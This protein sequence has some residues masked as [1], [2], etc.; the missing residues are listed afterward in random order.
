M[1]R[2]RPIHCDPTR[3]QARLRSRAAAIAALIATLIAASGCHSSD[4]PAPTGADA[5]FEDA[6]ESARDATAQDATTMDGTTL[7]D[8]ST[9]RLGASLVSRRFQVGEHMRASIEMQLSG[10]PFAQLLGYNLN[11]FVRT[12]TI[13]DQYQ[14]T[15]TSSI[16]RD[17]LG[18]A[19]AI[20]SYE[21]SKQPM[22]NLSFESGAGLSLMFG[23]VLNPM[24]LIGDP[25]FELLKQR[26]QLFALEA[27]AEGATMVT[28]PAPRMNPLNYYGWPGLR[29]VFAEFSSFDPTI[30]PDP[31]VVQA[32]PIFGSLTYGTVNPPPVANY[33]CDYNSLNL[34]DRE[35][36]VD[37]TL[38]LGALGYVV[39]KQGLW[40]INYW[41]SL[42]DRS[43][44]PIISVAP[45][46][47]AEVGVPGNVVVGQY[48]DP[49]DPTGMSLI[50][51]VP[52]VYLGD[53]PIEGWQGQLMMDEIDNKSA[54]LLGTLTTTDGSRLS[55]LP[56]ILSAVD[57]DY[58]SP[59]RFFPAVV[60]VE[61]TKTTTVAA[62]ANKFFPRPSAFSVVDGTSR[63]EVLSGLIGG[64]AEAFAFTDQNNAAVG[65]SI[66]FLVTF[67]GDPFASDDGLAD[68]ESTL[69]DRALGI[70]KIALVDLDR[71]HLDP[72]AMVL[73]DTAS[74]SGGAIRR[75]THVDAVELALA[76]VALR[77]AYRS[78]NGSL[79]LYSNDT[80]DTLGALSALD[81]TSTAGASYTGTLSGHITV[82]IKT[83]AD[84]IVG[85]LIDEHGAVANG[86]DLGAA[87]RDPGP[88][89]LEAEA[90]VIR[91]L[92]EA[93][94]ATSD[95]RYRARAI[96]VYA[97]LSTRFWQSDV[98][99]Y[100]TTAGVDDLMQ[101]TPLRHG[102]LQGALRQ[103][104][105]LV[106]SSPG[107]SAE[108]AELL[109]RIKRSMKLVLNGWDD[110]NQDDRIQYPE[111][112]LGFGLEMAERA[113][114]GELGRFGD[115]GD[116]DE[117]CVR[118]ISDVKAPA[119][120]A[121][122][123]DLRRQN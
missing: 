1:S 67:D 38:D 29:P 53:I 105:K 59:L 92:L 69:H 81:Q 111:E 12:S 24:Q 89:T 73:V 4:H 32:C 36:Q 16:V 15:M 7:P 47:Q 50:N 103:Y 97:D 118:E 71:L 58:A 104:Y 75:G 87:R 57:Y 83:S 68:G 37:K 116:R 96:D 3:L 101:Y 112:C 41:V 115:M 93:Y 100:R 66:P 74:I 46:D 25:A 65:G 95:Q 77:N 114:T 23:P 45:G 19:L 107:R 123:I 106:A 54:L 110:R 52:G 44:N 17:P 48:P 99:I 76:I 70:L 42:H 60:G 117:D 98:R 86:Y 63:L 55:G 2:P 34:V 10:E 9:P 102:L 88:T 121:S 43:G 79:Q 85:S 33:E 30:H 31:G 20:E 84:F 94:L 40:S 5:A 80:P 91:A 39:W 120:L 28:V 27:Y 26:F 49:M 13:T 119:A 6:G 109:G 113:L 62:L 108:G 64:F 56:S 21:Y 18:Y 72:T 78:L 90:A 8:A 35:A 14:A 82:L 11:G 61:E 51:G 22:N 122:E